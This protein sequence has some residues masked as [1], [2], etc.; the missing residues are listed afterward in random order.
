MEEISG[1]L[2]ALFIRVDYRGLNKST[3]AGRL[4]LDILRT[5]IDRPALTNHSEENGMAVAMSRR[6][7][8]YSSLLL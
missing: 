4:I 6:R 7:G 3:H 1:V 8:G 2:C 5:K